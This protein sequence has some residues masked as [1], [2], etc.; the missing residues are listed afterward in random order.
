MGDLVGMRLCEGWAG[1]GARDII[2]AGGIFRQPVEPVDEA[3]HIGHEDIGN[4]EGAR[5]PFAPCQ[6]GSMCFSRWCLRNESISPYAGASPVMPEKINID[7]WQACR[8][9]GIQRRK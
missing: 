7:Q 1:R 6:T 2:A 8:L 4:G 5:Q 3:Q 9:D